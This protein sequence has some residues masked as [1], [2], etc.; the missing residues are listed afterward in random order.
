MPDWIPTH[1]PPRL[2]MPLPPHGK[3]VLAWLADGMLPVTAYVAETTVPRSRYRRA[4]WLV[5]R[6]TGAIALGANVIAWCDCLPARGPEGVADAMYRQRQ[7]GQE[8]EQDG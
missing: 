3:C 5:V 6:H 2:A 7:A 8:G 4:Q 1:N